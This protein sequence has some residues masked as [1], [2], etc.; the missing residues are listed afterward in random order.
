MARDYTPKHVKARGSGELPM[1]E[2][3]MLRLTVRG[4][5]ECVKVCYTEALFL[6]DYRLNER[7]LAKRAAERTVR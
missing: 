6:S 7:G 2:R 5:P 1:R 4:D 3:R